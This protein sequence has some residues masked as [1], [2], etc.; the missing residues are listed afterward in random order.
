M[1]AAA[2][3]AR[4]TLWHPFD[5]ALH[6]SRI[7]L[8]VFRVASECAESELPSE[9]AF[10]VVQGRRTGTG[11]FVNFKATGLIASQWRVSFR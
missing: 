4:T 10:V 1:E 3:F 11:C 2:R 9:L 7:Y 8:L 5:T 6:H